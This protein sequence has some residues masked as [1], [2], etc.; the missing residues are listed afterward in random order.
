M[1][2][3]IRSILQHHWGYKGFRPTQE[4]IIL[5]VMN[6]EDVLALLPTGGGKSLCYQVPALAMGKLCLVISPLISLMKDQVQRLRS[7]GI[8]ARSVSAD[9]RREEID[10][11][12]ERAA[13]GKLA[14]LYVSPERLS[15]DIFLA[16]LDRMSIGLVAVDEAHCIS[17]WGHDFRPA[18]R[19]IKELRVRLPG[20]PVLALTASATA[21]VASDIMQ[22]LLFKQ[23]QIVRGS[24]ERPELV[25]WVS[26][27]EDR[28][29]R[30][31]RVMQH[32]PGTSIVY[33]RDRRQT[34]RIAHFLSSHG[35]SAHAYHAGMDHVLRDRIQ[36]QWSEGVIRCAVATNAFGM[37]IDKAD[38]RSVVHLEPPP[39]LESYYQE[40]GRAGRDGMRAHA[41][42]LLSPGYVERA[43]EKVT[44]GYPSL[45]DVRRTYQAFADL[46][47][48]AIGAGS[49][50]SY[51]LDLSVL[52]KR[53]GLPAA[54]VHHALKALEFDGRVALSDGVNVP[55]RV[56]FTAD[57]RTVYHHRVEHERDGQLLEALL[58]LH[59]GLFEE[60]VNIDE[61]RISR[62]L[63]R[64]L[65]DVIKD[66]EHLERLGLLVY[67]K[68]SN[69]P[70]VT[71]LVPRS[72]TVQL[73][74][75]PTSL[76]LRRQRAMKRCEAMLDYCSDVECRALH[77][78]Q[79]FGAS[80]GAPCGVC[81]RCKA[82]RT[83]PTMADRSNEAGL[84][85]DPLPRD[86]RWQLDSEA[87][88]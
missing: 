73:R 75:E 23:E 6:G 19:R 26:H 39:D 9:M 80:G 11:V 55:S 85:L 76:E 30:L 27:G 50:E 37:G 79:Y 41:F 58:R 87:E 49:G 38:V 65:A 72:D 44:A 88:A 83:A 8:E 12:L 31:L 29:G 86:L 56:L 71:L 48:I 47:R 32:V 14:F 82:G 69:T 35:V 45:T 84:L 59:G 20:I 36:Q 77:L 46:Y 1:Q 64:P 3:K 42:L 74:L 7:L 13:S 10:N 53:A 68:R 24:F 78:M 57:N 34:V 60:A 2:A 43:R 61:A 33:V 5:R 28:M 21:E 15:S 52:A 67:R 18:Y 81:D 40:A 63:D 62:M 17:Q 70:L 16:R 66:L 54:T 51:A 4:D 22:E 25:L